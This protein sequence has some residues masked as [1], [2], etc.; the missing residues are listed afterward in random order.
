MIRISNNLWIGWLFIGLLALSSNSTKFAGLA[1]LVLI[2]AAFAT[3]WSRRET[4]PYTGQAVEFA[5]NWFFLCL[6]A[7]SLRAIAQIYWSDPWEKRHFD[8]RLVL[9]AL[10]TWWLLQYR[11]SLSITLNKLIG[12]LLLAATGGLMVV[13]LHV[14]LGMPTPSNRINWTLGLGFLCCALLGLTFKKDITLKQKLW[15]WI[16]IFIYLL[17]I[18]FSGVRGAYLIFPWA[19][20]IGIYQLIKNKNNFS[21]FNK[22]AIY[23][24]IIISSIFIVI[25]FYTL[26]SESSPVQRIFLAIHEFNMASASMNTQGMAS[27]TSIGARMYLWKKA[28]HLIQ[29]SPWIGI[30]MTQRIEEIKLLGEQIQST[31]I[32]S[33][34]HFHNEFLNNWVE[35]G[36][37]GILSTL[38]YCLGLLGLG[39]KLLRLHM[40][41]G[42]AIL[43]IGLMHLSAS[44]S[45]LNTSHNNYG[46]MLSISIFLA[47]YLIPAALNK[48]SEYESIARN[49]P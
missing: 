41:T 2:A 48:R 21:Q 20:I 44:F 14:H 19:M 6:L 9:G 24:V 13:G 15:S 30:G 39:Y 22:L 38:T 33:L 27:E 42:V 40:V 47:F 5:R 1:W 49:P 35:H 12:T 29:A 45:N 3:R 43:G 17:A 7:F 31:T 36:I 4:N 16:G 11:P 28:I 26:N 23:T 25:F 32:G 37:Y 34:S 10:A 8:L 46:V 18:F